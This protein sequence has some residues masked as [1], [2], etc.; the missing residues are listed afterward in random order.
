[1]TL[2]IEIDLTARMLQQVLAGTTDIA[3][4][5]GPVENPGI[6]TCG[7]GSVGL[8]WL[9]SPGTVAQ[10]GL[11]GRCRYGRCPRIRRSTR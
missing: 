11:R 8:V 2:E 7:I 10:G 3:F 9:A 6:R 5:A 4:L 1:V